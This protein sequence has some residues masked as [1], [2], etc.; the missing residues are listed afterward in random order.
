MNS[1]GALFGSLDFETT[2]EESPRI[3]AGGFNAFPETKRRL[4]RDCQ[5]GADTASVGRVVACSCFCPVLFVKRAFEGTIIRDF[6]V[7]EL[8]L[9]LEIFVSLR[10]DSAIVVLT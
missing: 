4:N 1:V 6:S 5:R 8:V 2:D 3:N 7:G 10:S 9:A